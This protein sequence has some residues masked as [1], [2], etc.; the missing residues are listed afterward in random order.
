MTEFSWDSNKPD[1]GG[2]KMSILKKWV[3]EAMHQ[4]WKA[5]VSKFF[6]LSLRDWPRQP[7]LPYSETYESG[8]YFRGDSTE[9]DRSKA[10]PQRLPLSFRRL[11]AV[12]KGLRV[13]GRTPDPRAPAAGG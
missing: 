9:Q 7:G 12:K 13:W 5:G 3:P 11:R 6:W 8:L 10:D 1:P 4:A 2:V